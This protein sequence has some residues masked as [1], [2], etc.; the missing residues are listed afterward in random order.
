MSEFQELNQEYQKLTGKD[1]FLYATQPDPKGKTMYVF[2]DR[3]M[4]N[5]GNALEFMRLSVERA[6]LN[7]SAGEQT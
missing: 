6:R 2:T 7:L 5:R 4:T 3:N 1:L